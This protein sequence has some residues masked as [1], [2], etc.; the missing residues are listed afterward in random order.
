MRCTDLRPS[1]LALR[2]HTRLPKNRPINLLVLVDMD[3]QHFCDVGVALVVKADYF[4]DLLLIRRC[5]PG[6]QA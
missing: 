3:F 6:H 4:A 5:K 1:D 2:L